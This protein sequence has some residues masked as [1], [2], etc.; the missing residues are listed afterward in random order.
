[1]STTPMTF[2]ISVTADR[3][4]SAPA[5][6][7]RFIIEVTNKQVA[8]QASDDPEERAEFQ[9]ACDAFN[10]R[11]IVLRLCQDNA[12]ARIDDP[13]LDEVV[14]NICSKRHYDADDFESAL[15]AIQHRVRHPF[16]LQPLEIA[17]E[18][19]KGCPVKLV[20]QSVAL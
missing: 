13:F 16:G 6:F 19:A 3:H 11:R 2:R 20:D 5:E 9:I 17:F 18:R 15:E 8:R 10:F 12:V 14:K 4:L 1:M 7:A